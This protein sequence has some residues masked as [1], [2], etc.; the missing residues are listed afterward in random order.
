MEDHLIANLGL[1]SESKVLD[2]GCGVGHVAIHLAQ[3]VG[4]RINAIDVVERHIEKARRNV[5]AWAWRT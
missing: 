5:R 2:A 1:Q 3:T 4:W